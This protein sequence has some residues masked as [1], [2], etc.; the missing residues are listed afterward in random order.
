MNSCKK[1]NES[2]NGNYCPNCGQPAQLKRID[3]HYFIQEIASAFNAEKGM[4]YTIKRMLT[5]P[6]NSVRQYITEDRSQYVKPITFLFTTSVIYAFVNHIFHV[7]IENYYFNSDVLK[8]STTSLIFG[9]LMNNRGYAGIIIGFLMT[10][11]I[12]LFYR[13]SGYNFYE[14]FV[15]LC[16]VSGIST[17]FLSVV[18]LLQVLTPTHWN[19][20]KILTPIAVVYHI[21]SVGQFFDAKKVV[22]YI[23]AFLSFI[24]GATIL[25]FIVTLIGFLID[26]IIKH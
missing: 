16:F 17:L 3:R 6:G 20:I 9:W 21:W 4:L 12:K 1:C 14:I 2:F 7:G 10:F 24:F 5:S 18:F 13:K 19:L 15:L 23:K 11:W 8:Q 26:I 25:S 22:S